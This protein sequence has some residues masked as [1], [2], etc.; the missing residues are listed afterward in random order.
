MR[1]EC[2]LSLGCGAEE[3]LRENIKKALEKEGTK[4]DVIFYRIKDEEAQVF[5]LRGS[6]SVLINGKDIEPQEISGFS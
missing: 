3:G 5:G 4:A 2:Y 6:P 1:I